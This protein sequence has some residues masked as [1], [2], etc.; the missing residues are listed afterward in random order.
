MPIN[1]ERLEELVRSHNERRDNYRNSFEEPVR[2]AKTIEYDNNTPT[3]TNKR[4]LE[5]IGVNCQYVEE[6]FHEIVA[7]LSLIGV[8]VIYVGVPIKNAAKTLEK[9]INE[10]VREHWR[11]EGMLD[12]IEIARSV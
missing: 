12:V 9:A 8:K 10:E 11:S 7:S 2:M 6:N 1:Y 4:Q 5:L 3:T